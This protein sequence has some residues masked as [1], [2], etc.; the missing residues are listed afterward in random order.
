ARCPK[1]SRT[2]SRASSSTARNRR[3]PRS[4]SWGNWTEEGSVPVSRSASPRTE[5]R[6]STKA[7]TAH[8]SA[9]RPGKEKALTS[10]CNRWKRERAGDVNLEDRA[11]PDSS[12]GHV[13]VEPGA[14]SRNGRGGDRLR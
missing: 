1:S 6:E 7:A 3:S 2:A 4:T 10:I 11:D 5:W 13:D 14:R 12:D 9:L 8:W